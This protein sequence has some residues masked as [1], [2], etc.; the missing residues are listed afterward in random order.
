MALIPS[1]SRQAPAAAIIRLL[2][3]V[4]VHVLL[5]T[6]CNAEPTKDA[7]IQDVDV[8][9][10][11]AR[12]SSYEISALPPRELQ[13]TLLFPGA[14]F[15]E[16]GL[17]TVL[18]VHVNS[19]SGELQRCFRFRM[20][21]SYSCS[22]NVPVVND[23]DAGDEFNWTSPTADVAASYI[24][25][26][27]S[28]YAALGPAAVD[29]VTLGALNAAERTNVTSLYLPYPPCPGR[30]RRVHLGIFKQ[31]TLR[32]A[33]C[34]AG[35]VLLCIVTIDRVYNIYDSTAVC[36]AIYRVCGLQVLLW[37][38]LFLCSCCVPLALTE[39]SSHSQNSMTEH[40]FSLHT[41]TSSCP[42]VYC[43]SSSRS[44]LPIH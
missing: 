13:A 18:R 37:F 7:C 27:S 40:R 25:S 9:S 35:S 32:D 3:V 10:G 33:R 21:A 2:L 30:E 11:L 26:A 15:P 31:V 34:V 1:R 44:S 38:L 16:N 8:D 29:V 22:L 17:V 23:L 12:I 24:G 41:S 43:L 42:A 36:F 6:L 20:S 5:A 19:S 39:T 4:I 28:L 14:A